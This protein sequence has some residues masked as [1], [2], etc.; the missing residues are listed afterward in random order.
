MGF[1]Q[2][3]RQELRQSL[4]AQ[5]IQYVAVLQM[6]V[7]ELQAYLSEMQLENPL[8]EVEPPEPPQIDRVDIMRWLISHP[9][10]RRED[11]PGDENAPFERRCPTGNAVIWRST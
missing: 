6:T 7:L 4:S 11:D 2:F 1:G 9:T 8:L 10:D 5:Q 3:Q